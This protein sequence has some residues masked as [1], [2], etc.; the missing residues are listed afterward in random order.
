MRATARGSR[1]GGA[2]SA[3]A[4]RRAARRWPRPA[5][6]VAWKAVS[7]QATAGTSGSSAADRVERGERPGLVQRREVGELAEAPTR[8]R[9]RSAPASVKRVPPWTIRWPTASALPSA[10]SAARI[11]RRGRRPRRSIELALGDRLVGGTE[12]RELE[13]AR[14]GVDDEDAHASCRPP[15]RSSR[16]S[17]AG[18][19][20]ARGCRRGAQ[21]RVD[22]LLAQVR[23]R[24]RRAPGR[25]RSRPSPG[26]SGR[27]R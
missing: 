14:A 7:K 21:P 18:R 15:A 13:A 26:G 2:A 27:G 9:R 11:P 10:A 8:P 1:S 23:A 5:G 3:R 24:A 17:P 4:T 22:H 25:G 19:R 20:R 12:Q 16:G 6:I